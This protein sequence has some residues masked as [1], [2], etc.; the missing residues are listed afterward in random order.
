MEVKETMTLLLV[1]LFVASLASTVGVQAKAMVKV[2]PVTM[3]I[4]IRASSGG[5]F[6]ILPYY[7]TSVFQ[8]LI[9]QPNIT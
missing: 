4:V 8:F 1:A 2:A 3:A 7:F 6:Y 5:S 9:H